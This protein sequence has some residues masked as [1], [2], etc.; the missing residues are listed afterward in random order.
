VSATSPE[1]AQISVTTYEV[2]RCLLAVIDH[3]VSEDELLSSTLADVGVES[4]A[5]TAF[6][7]R[8][9]KEFGIK[10]DYDVPLDVFRSV[11]TIA[12]YIDSVRNLSAV[13]HFITGATGFLGSALSIELLASDPNC[14]IVC[15][16][17]SKSKQSALGR[18]MTTLRT[19][20]KLYQYS[21]PD[22]SERVSVVEGD[23]DRLPES[24]PPVNVAWHTAGSLKYL[25]RDR[26]E[27]EAVNVAAVKRMVDWLSYHGV[28]QLNHFSTA[29]VFGQR[30][31]DCAET[32]DYYEYEPNNAYEETKRAGE[33][34][35]RNSGLHWRIMRPSIVVG[36][37]HTY[38][39]MSDSGVYGFL[40]K[41]LMFKG[42][43]ARVF[44]DLYS[45]ASMHLITTPSVRVDLIPIDRCVR[46]GVCAGERVDPYSVIHLTNSDG[47]SMG[48]TLLSIFEACEMTAPTFVSQPGL[49]SDIDSKFSEE[50]DF[51]APY[52]RQEKRFLQADDEIAKISNVTVDREDL[53]QM[54]TRWIKSRGRRGRSGS[55]RHDSS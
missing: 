50:I 25:D 10:W 11:R 51:Y 26:A 22:L 40:K 54:L 12:N 16:S 35:V 55:T 13:K 34:V 42:R 2:I 18:T 14:E 19:A 9:E 15:L 31:G 47:P 48:D 4:W 24:M 30:E 21:V 43:I 49:L 37:S 6:L 32:S 23:F 1:P 20:A 28:R 29:Y 46:A 41:T 38:Q 3:K 44:G 17:R 5:F 27:I 36:H 45:N 33:L 39:G 53:N 7:A 8:V 52:I